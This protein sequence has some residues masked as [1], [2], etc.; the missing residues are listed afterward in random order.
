MC[1]LFYSNGL[2]IAALQQLSHKFLTV[3]HSE[4]ALFGCGVVNPQ[5]FLCGVPI[6]ASAQPFGFLATA[7]KAAL[8]L[9]TT[10]SPSGVP[11]WRLT[12]IHFKYYVDSWLFS[13]RNRGWIQSVTRTGV[14]CRFLASNLGMASS[15]LQSCFN[16]IK[17][18]SLLGLFEMERFCMM[19]VCHRYFFV[20]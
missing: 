15:W 5:A 17:G 19:Q 8:S 20:E 18:L 1:S 14:R 2:L 13:V 7:K 10:L 4:T 11:G 9:Y 16:Y 3:F 12:V 6:F